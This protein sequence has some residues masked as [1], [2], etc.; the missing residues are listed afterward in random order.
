VFERYGIGGVRCG[1]STFERQEGTLRELR[2][3]FEAKAEAAKAEMA[4]DA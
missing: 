4:K 2:K 1:L 3:A